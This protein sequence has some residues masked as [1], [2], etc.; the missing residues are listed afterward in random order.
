VIDLLGFVYDVAK[1][2]K[3]YLTWKEEE[4]LIDFNWPVKSG[5]Q[6]KAE[7]DG[8][9]IAWSRPD[10]IASRE[11]DGYEIVYEVDKPKRIR[12]RL[13]LKDGSVLIGK[14]QQA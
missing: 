2:V 6:A 13:V 11:L 12:R 9:K 10:R 5:F 7:G 8:L 3:E 14:R 1:D 4:K